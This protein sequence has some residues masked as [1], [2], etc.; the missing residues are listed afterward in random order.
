MRIEYIILLL[1]LFS[2]RNEA[3]NQETSVPR[4]YKITVDSKTLY[5]FDYDKEGRLIDETL[6]LD[7]D[8][9]FRKISYSYSEGKLISRNRKEKQLLVN[10]LTV[11]PPVP[12]A[13]Q[14]PC[15]DHATYRMLTDIPEYDQAGRVTK[16]V[17]EE[18]VAEYVYDPDG[19]VK[20]TLTLTSGMRVHKKSSRYN[21]AGNL[22][23][24]KEETNEG[25]VIPGYPIGHYYGNFSLGCGLE[26]YE[27]DA[28]RNPLYTAVIWP[29]QVPNNLVKRYGEENRFAFTWS[30]TY[31]EHGFPLERI[32]SD[33]AKWVYHYRQ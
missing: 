17:N 21:S 10:Q 2:C 15:G 23:E 5:T 25:N 14:E 20:A 24:E 30:Y 28:G 7:C 3:V 18:S 31:N 33:G 19:T 8:T 6:Y 9:E 4:L 26:K 13:I 29:F 12:P 1:L 16:I 11:N 27:Y 32:G 22:M